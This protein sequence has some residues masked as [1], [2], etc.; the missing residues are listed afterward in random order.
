MIEVS[1]GSVQI[2]DDSSLLCNI[3]NRS[4]RRYFDDAVFESREHVVL[5]VHHNVLW[6]G[7]SWRKCLCRR[8][9]CKEDGGEQHEVFHS[10]FLLSFYWRR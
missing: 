1:P 5:A 8:T 6:R 10:L 2:A 3:C 9:N 7:N 4:V